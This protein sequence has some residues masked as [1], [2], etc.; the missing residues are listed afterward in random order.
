MTRGQIAVITPDGDILTSVEFNG[1]M[2]MN[3]CGFGEEVFTELSDVESVEEYAALVKKFNAAH[4]G[5]EGNLLEDAPQSFLDMKHDYFNK[6]FSD[7]VY[8]KNLSDSPVVFTDKKG[9]NIRIESDITAVFYYGEFLLDNE[10]DLEKRIFIDDLTEFRQKLDYDYNTTYCKLWNM[11][12][13]FDNKHRT[14]LT[15]FITNYDFVTEDILEYVVKENA[16]DLCRL[17]NFIGDTYDADIY[18]LDGY[19]NLANVDN[20]DF[21]DVIDELIENLQ[22][23]IHIPLKEEICL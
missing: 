21:E 11:C 18:R 6:W 23:Q 9:R 3:G 15:D 14:S 1:S 19:G 12:A 16:T 10:E 20:G 13:D 22:D 2:Y 4:F 17:R 7:Y 5:Y 8:I